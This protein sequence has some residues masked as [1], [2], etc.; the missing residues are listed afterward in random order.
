MSFSLVISTV[1]RPSVEVPPIFALRIV[2]DAAGLARQ[3][4]AG[5]LHDSVTQF[6]DDLLGES[7]HSQSRLMSHFGLYVNLCAGDKVTNDWSQ[8][9][10]NY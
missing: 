8:A 6:C 7:L 1:P 2:S 4:L 10:K 5:D 9:L 3:K